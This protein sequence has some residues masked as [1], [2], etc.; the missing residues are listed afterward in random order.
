MSGS[1]VDAAKRLDDALA[2]NHSAINDADDEL[3]DAVLKATSSSDEGR[4]RL[5]GLQQE[6]VDEVNKLD[7]TL[8]TAPGQQQL[9]E[10]LQN[11]TGDIL[12]VLKNGS[13]DA[14]SQAK[15]LDGLTARYQALHDGGKGS[16]DDPSNP[17]GTP[18]DPG[19][20]PAPG[21][22]GAPGAAGTD[23]GDTGGAGDD[24]PSLEGGLPSDAMM[25]G[26]GALGPA[27]GALGWLP[28]G[29]GFGH[30]RA[31]RR[32]WRLG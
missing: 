19:G 31:W 28:F 30:S 27:M 10:F 7:S 5:Q 2:K 17:G 21:A 3:A 12:D 15:V 26:L 13:L 4:K 25:G 16:G 20:T 23:P 14:D 22:P 6:I 24:D 29:V 11:K 1:A 18:Q 32:W 8:D 9:A